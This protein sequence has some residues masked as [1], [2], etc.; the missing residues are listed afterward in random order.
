MSV[1]VQQC[2]QCSGSGLFFDPQIQ[3]GQYGT[4]KLCG[5]I[6]ENC[7]CGGRKPYQY[8]DEESRRQWCSCRPARLRLIQT[9]KNFKQAELPARYR[10]KFI[11]DFKA[12]TPD[13]VAIPIAEEA[14]HI[15]TSIMDRADEP[16]RG[17]LLHSKP[18]TGKTLLGCIV[19][20]E[21]MLHRKRPG[22]FLNSPKFFQQLKDTYSEDS[23]QYGRTWQMID[24]LCKVP[25]LVLDDFGVQR[26]TEWELEM[27]YNLID[28]RYSE[29]R[30]TIVTTNQPMEELEKVHMGRI[31][32]RLREM[33][34]FIHMDGV[35]YRQHL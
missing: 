24:A 19:L 28:A 9:Q 18:G 22:R 32:S 15:V 31:Y 16:E 1:S 8:W 30:F 11:D 23:D 29:K 17:F 20:N 14:V 4:L 35:D 7:R 34:F 3:A 13:G 25:Y 27:S 12:Q 33:C 5:C 26:G 6:K 2:R 10:W 21:L